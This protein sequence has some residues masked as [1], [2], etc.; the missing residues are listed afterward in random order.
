M[1]FNLN[2]LKK[3]ARVD[4]ATDYSTG[5]YLYPPRFAWYSARNPEKIESRIVKAIR[6][7]DFNFAVYVHFP[8]CASRCT[9]CRFYS[10]ANQNLAE[11][12]TMLD[13]LIKE[14]QIWA[15]LIKSSRKIK[16]KIPLESIY[17]GGGTPTL[18]NLEKFFG[19]LT[20]KFDISRCRQINLES[21]PDALN[22]E[23]LRFYKKIGVNRL[24]IGIQSLDPK[25]LAAVNRFSRQI[26]V[27]KKNH[28]FARKIGIPGIN[29]ELIAGLPKQTVKNFLRDL[30]ELIKL[31][32]D[33]IHVYR[34]LT[35]P[36]SALGKAGYRLDAEA[37]LN[38]RKMLLAAEKLLE[39]AGYVRSGDEW[40]LR[41]KESAR[42][43]QL[44][45]G[46]PNLLAIGPSASGS[47]KTKSYNF[48]FFNLL[49][50][51]KY[52]ERVFYSPRILKRCKEVI[53]KKYSHLN[54]NNLDF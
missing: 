52:K 41:K 8:F 9:F 4:F 31:K 29:F 11:Y 53:R 25:V 30:A 48:Y 44:V 23:K 18:F 38:C 36:L 15:N 16:G 37:R 14:L 7:S 50:I 26:D 13:Y 43:F 45:S 20:K 17:L 42:N 49:N 54:F 24:L 5:G 47:I 39:E 6:A 21:A 19:V 40:I 34:F 32:P 10:L 28:N 2:L 12:E 51:K 3:I 22:E 27:L 35:T 1:S 33:G 46:R